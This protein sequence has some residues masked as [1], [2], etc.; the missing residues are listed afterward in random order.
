MTSLFLAILSALLLFFR[1]SAAAQVRIDEVLPQDR[2][3]L[4]DEE[5]D[6]RGWVELHNSGPSNVN[7][8]GYGL[9][10]DPADPFR[11][12]FPNLDL[13]PD[14]R[15]IVFTDGKDRRIPPDL[16]V[17][18]PGFNPSNLIGINVWVDASDASTLRLNNGRLSEWV[19]KAPQDPSSASV[20]ALDP[21]N[22]AGKILWLD[23]ADNSQFTLVQ[24]AVSVWKDKSGLRNDA[25]Q[26]TSGNRPLRLTATAGSA[27]LVRFDGNNDY[28]LFQRRME[29]I[30][31][32]FFVGREAAHVDGVLRP[33]LG[34]SEF[35]DFVRGRT[36]EL[37][38]DYFGAS[39]GGT[40]GTWRLNGKR[41]LPLTTR[42]PAGAGS[43]LNLV[44]LVA[45]ANMRAN[46]LSWERFL[47]IGDNLNE[48]WNGDMAEILCFD[49]ELSASEVA[50]IEKYLR[51]KWGT[52]PLPVPG[53]SNPRQFIAEFQPALVVD[54][55]TDQRGI[56]FDGINDAMGMDLSPI[57]TVFWVGREADTATD[58]YRPIL[59]S[60]VGYD[61]V[62]GPNRYIFFG[63]EHSVWVNGYSVAPE[64]TPLPPGRVLLS[65][66][67]T[68]DTHVDNLA[69]DRP[70]DLVGRY[71]HGEINE[72]IA[73]NRALTDLER[74]QM[75]N[76]LT[77][78]WRL[79]AQN[80]HTNFKLYGRGEILQL[81]R[82]DASIA[83]STPPIETRADVSFGRPPGSAAWQWYA[84]PGPNRP[85]S[86][87]VTAGV[88]PMPIFSPSP[89]MYTGLVKVSLITSNLPP[90]STIEY[91][92]DGSPPAPGNPATR[93]YS[94]P[95]TFVTSTVIR[96]RAVSANRVPSGTATATYLQNTPPG[97]PV[98]SL[99]TT[100]SNLFDP[101]WGMYVAG[102]APSPGLPSFG[103]EN[104]HQ[105]WE[106]PVHVEFFETNGV[107][108]FDLDCGLRICGG[109]SRNFPQKSLCLRFRDRYGSDA[110]KY[111][112][113]PG[114]TVDKFDSL[115]LRNGGND[116]S[117]AMLRDGLA[118]SLG[119]EIGLETHRYRPAHVYINGQYWGIHEIRERDDVTHLARHTEL[120]ASQ[121]SLV[122]DEVEVS[123]GTR[124]DYDTLVSEVAAMYDT[125]AGS[126]ENEALYASVTNHMDVDNYID[127]LCLEFFGDNGDWPGH[128][129]LTWR[130][131]RP[132]GKW[133]WAL[134]DLD[135]G[136]TPWDLYDSGREDSF[137][138]MFGP[139]EV[140]GQLERSVAFTRGLVKNNLWRK[141]FVNR[142]ADLLN[143]TF[144]PEHTVPRLEEFRA[145]L[146]PGMPAHI[147]RWAG[148]FAGYDTIGSVQNW[149]ASVDV[150]RSFL[151][152]RPTVL[153]SIISARLPIDGSVRVTLGAGLGAG[154]GSLQ[155]S[156][157]H[158]QS[159]NLPWAGFYFLRSP[160]EARATPAPGYR[161]IGWQGRSETNNP[162]VFAMDRDTFVTP[163]FGLDPNYDFSSLIP[164]P[165]VLASGP[166]SLTAWAPDSTAG[167]YPASMRFLQTSVKDPDIAA[168]GETVWTNRYDLADRSRILGLGADGFA[169]RNT[170][171]SQSKDEGY[172]SSALLA[173]RTDQATNIQV[174]WTGG[175]AVTNP[176]PYAIRLEWRIG[177]DGLFNSVLDQNGTPVE[178]VASSSPG[179]SRR[180][181]PVTLPVAAE[182]QP[183]IQLRWKYYSIASATPS[184]G[185]PELRVDDVLVTASSTFEPTRTTFSHFNLATG[186]VTLKFDGPGNRRVGLFASIDLTR[187]DQVA[188]GTSDA[189]GF[190][191]LSHNPT[192][193]PAQYY[194]IRL[195]P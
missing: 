74:V 8:T 71:W 66:S 78:K 45:P 87:G 40:N 157:L 77:R 169:F 113:F 125:L 81:T 107:A 92:T 101:S 186:S 39:P 176:R 131:N 189:A 180:F 138:F 3:V 49:R 21:K 155:F 132:G 36:G 56:L 55:L 50:G 61:F 82:P 137:I 34:D 29:T 108:G 18:P 51:Q 167:T 4:A 20:A 181:G 83:D 106:R 161:F 184:G 195:I 178:Y 135:A 121:I 192:G 26:A 53:A 88:V 127:W 175:T 31:T 172:A 23:A 151:T 100:S 32:V 140:L 14:R 128:N 182:G 67:T 185:R 104:W 183:V 57:R 136:F 44:S 118:E 173:L 68:Y 33:I 114:S 171:D 79:P 22:V 86:G 19:D 166:Y 98:V 1:G 65:V 69:A 60:T 24:S 35:Y 158:F 170:S 95:L 37:L 177:T 144:A 17:P 73:F 75:E 80:L 89:G 91:T 2:T 162:L 7:L 25:S 93:T 156:T 28:L 94:L 105:D 116:W 38:G 164:R 102:P 160:V 84:T 193:A 117:E 11:W 115:I 48:V 142:L 63:A 152:N 27:A 5:N 110:L 103:G 188:S 97:L 12:R 143:T 139:V 52:P 72:I 15:L 119:A 46:N 168:A 13:P 124:D 153:R 165:H 134:T 146:A 42:F 179:H 148:P 150:V 129:I 190:V 111:P 194:Q 149:T 64:K 191:A 70:G 96:A 163:L 90:G 9:S 41:V 141:R 112:L 145:R 126:P 109:Y 62:R 47:V 133:R 58:N 187:W 159:A 154:L 76:Y 43:G 6:H 147:Q 85:N 99:A 16:S 123:A 10:D 122:R 130:D 174:S 59:G 54:P 120:P 30:R